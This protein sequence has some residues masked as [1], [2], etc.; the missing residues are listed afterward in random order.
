MRIHRG[1]LATVVLA[2][3]GLSGLAVGAYYWLQQLPDPSAASRDELFRWLV[4]RDVAAEP[5][6]VQQAL[7]DRLQAELLEGPPTAGKAT[8][9]GGGLRTQLRDNVHT[10][11]RVWFE[12]RTRQYAACPGEEKFDFLERQIALV[13][14]WSTFESDVDDSDADDSGDGRQPPRASYASE[15]FDEIEQWIAESRGEQHE[16][17]VCGV[18]DGLVCWL[19]TRSLREQPM[20]LRRDLAVRI[21]RE[22]DYGGDPG[23]GGDAMSEAQRRQLGENGLL[24][25]EA[26]LGQQALVYAEL[27]PKQRLDFLNER[28]DA[29]E[30]WNIASLVAADSSSPGDAPPDPA[31]AL[32]RLS[33]EIDVWIERADPT[34]RDALRTLADD[35]RAQIAW[36]ALRKLLPSY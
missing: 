28:I 36:R 24:L 18:Q 26:W 20:S 25:M 35:L 34:E 4:L 15:F 31:A 19:A 22:L 11:K 12:M 9:L 2:A 7:V 8:A 21:A 10:L 16:Q 27:E 17:M 3:L 5:L 32:V 14:A 33:A 13:A 30:R 6:D 23:V 1:I 29:F